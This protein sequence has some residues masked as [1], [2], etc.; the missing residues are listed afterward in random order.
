MQDNFGD[1]SQFSGEIN[2]CGPEEL[3]DAYYDF[4]ALEDQ[5]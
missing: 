4:G 5:T 1:L 2:E 3:T